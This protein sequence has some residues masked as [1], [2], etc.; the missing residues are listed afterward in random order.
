MKS[1]KKITALLMCAVMVFALSGVSSAGSGK[2]AS[3]EEFVPVLRFVAG[4]D[5]HVRDDSDENCSRISKMM[6]LAYGLA[7]KDK[8]YSKLDA[9][10]IAGDITND[11]TKTE[12][13]KVAQTIKDSLRGDTRFLGVGAKNHDG[14]EL[15]RTELRDYY[16]GVTGNL[17]L[18]RLYEISSVLTEATRNNENANVDKE[19][20]EL[21]EAYNLI[22]TEYEK[23]LA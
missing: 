1:L 10:V 2:R 8:N 23:S 3:A 5:T 14:Y 20:E 4:S 9:L 19:I 11:G 17:A 15:K 22:K 18:T 16:K 21:K 13:D 7:E 12:F 6:N